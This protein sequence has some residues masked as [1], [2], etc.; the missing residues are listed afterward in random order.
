MALPVAIGAVFAATIVPLVI[1]VMAALGLGFVTYTGVNLLL[2]TIGADIQSQ[3]ASISL[4]GLQE[5]LA[6]MNVDVAITMMLSAVVV[7]ATLK[8]LGAGG[9]LRRLGFLSS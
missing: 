3:F 8:G 5:L 7:R 6:Y 2:D 9:D 1:K 4:Q